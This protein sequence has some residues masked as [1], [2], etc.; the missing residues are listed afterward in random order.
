M[1]AVYAKVDQSLKKSNSFI[2]GE[3]S[4]TYYSLQYK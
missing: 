3:I 1:I 4:E 2:N